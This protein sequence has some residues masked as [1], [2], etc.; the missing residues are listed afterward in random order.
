MYYITSVPRCRASAQLLLSLT[1]QHW[2]AIENG[3]H[4][5]RD[6]A[7]GEDACQIFRGHAPQNLA[8]F[9]NAGLNLL[10]RSGEQTILPKI[11]SL[12]WNPQPLF[13]SFGYPN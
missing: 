2:G 6:Q 11:R 4:Y 1:R 13:C 9:R 5:V 7:L 3:L 8:A 10:R 12:T